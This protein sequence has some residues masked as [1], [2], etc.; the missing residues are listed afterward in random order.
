MAQE[1]IDQR[2]D[3]AEGWL[4]AE[5]EAQRYLADPANADEIARMATSRPRASASRTS[6]TRSTRR[7]RSSRADEATACAS[8]CRS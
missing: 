7:G 6:A 5:L 2:P 8:G 1:L 4:K 3:I